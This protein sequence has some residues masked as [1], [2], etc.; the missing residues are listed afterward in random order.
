MNK[1]DQRKI[2]RAL[3]KRSLELAERERSIT[4]QVV[5]YLRTCLE[6][7]ELPQLAGLLIALGY[8]RE[9]WA[10]VAKQFPTIANRAEH[11]IEKIWV[12]KLLTPG[13]AGAAFYLK[14]TFRDVYKDK[15]EQDI[16]LKMPK[17]I[18]EGVEP[19]TLPAKT[20][21]R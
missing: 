21:T 4:L 9:E 13:S 6:E 16:T 10:A 14:N 15:T 2:D 17:P 12:E 1:K 8:S 18:L 7:K 5:T 3:A 19:I 11:F 20:I